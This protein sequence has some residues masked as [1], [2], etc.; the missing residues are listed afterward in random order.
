M[1]CVTDRELDPLSIRNAVIAISQ[2]D[3]L[4]DQHISNEKTDRRIL[5]GVDFGCLCFAHFQTASTDNN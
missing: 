5:G 1:P 2:I 4:A 3:I